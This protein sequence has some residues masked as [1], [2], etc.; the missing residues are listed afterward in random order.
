MEIRQLKLFLAIA[1]NGSFSRVATLFASTQSAV[2][3]SISALEQ[4]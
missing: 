1:A 4:E 2:S 3:K